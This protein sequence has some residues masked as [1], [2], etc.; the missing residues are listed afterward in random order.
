VK[1][2]TKVR[3]DFYNTINQTYAEAF[4]GQIREWCEENDVLHTGH[5]LYEEYLR[6][7]SRC[8]G[9]LFN[10]LKEL[11]IIGVD[12]LY[13]RIG[14]EERAEEHVALKLGSSAASSFLASTRLLCESLGATYWGDCTM[15]A[16][17]VDCRLGV[18]A[19]RQFVQSP[20]FPLF[21]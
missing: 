12:H 13:P 8:E 5:L 11:H 9:N 3:Y 4:Y 10:L 18:C 15:G 6:L 2:T 20:W 21:Y 19:G 16:D 17:E 7:Q 1:K 14:N